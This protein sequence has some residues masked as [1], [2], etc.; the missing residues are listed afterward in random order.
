LLFA[1]FCI[2]GP[3]G[4]GLK[5]FPASGPFDAKN[6]RDKM[7]DEYEGP[8]LDAIEARMTSTAMSLSRTRQLVWEPE[9]HAR[10]RVD[11]PALI[12]VHT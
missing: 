3:D 2:G 10:P 4:I 8:E 11:D 5:A 6:P 7:A 1:N 9:L 12:P